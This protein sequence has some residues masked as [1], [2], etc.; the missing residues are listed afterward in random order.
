MKSTRSLS[1]VKGLLLLLLTAG[2]SPNGARA[3][4][5][6]EGKFTLPFEARWGRAILPP[7]DYAF[8][9]QSTS[10]PAI[11]TVRRG[12]RGAPTAMIAAQGY[13]QA[14]PAKRNELVFARR[15]RQ[16]IVESLHLEDLGFIFRYP[17][18]QAEK[19]L[20]VRSPKL[21]QQGSTLGA[22]K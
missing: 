5:A 3:Q 18:P 16:L 2:L 22:A 21:A 6:V 14:T 8:S 15:G 1:L 12:S 9:I 13:D 19:E 17:I 10:L 20:V 4:A 7:G 11:V